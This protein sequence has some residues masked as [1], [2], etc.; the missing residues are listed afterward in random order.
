MMLKMNRT[1]LGFP[2]LPICSGLILCIDRNLYY[3]RRFIGM[4]IELLDGFLLELRV[5]G[6]ESVTC[7]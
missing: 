3:V 5:G 7:S 1:I 6:I 2:I 4:T